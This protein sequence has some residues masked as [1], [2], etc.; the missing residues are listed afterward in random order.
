MTSPFLYPKEQ[1]RRRLRPLKLA[2]Y[3]GYKPF[4]RDEFSKKC[5]YC[6]VP[7]GLRGSGNFGVDHYRPK[8]IFPNLASTY[9]NL[10]YCCNQCNSRKSDYWHE[11]VEQRIP[12]PCDDV[13]TR[14]VR[15]AD[16]AVETISDRGR[17]FAELLDLNDPEVV[18]FR[19]MVNLTLK[20]H[21][22][23]RKR[24]LAALARLREL[25]AAGRST[26]AAEDKIESQVAR[27]DAAVAILL[28]R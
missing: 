23:E 11:K 10:F 4:L 6:R 9:T 21:A 8:S 15:F 3:Q 20:T 5:V 18:G 26:R 25:S 1:H 14:H 27:I 7:D 12:N 28:G 17:L 13:M 24:A 19:R 22:A 16:G 2:R